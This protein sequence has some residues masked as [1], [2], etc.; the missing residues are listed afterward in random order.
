MRAIVY[1]S[2][3]EPEVLELADVPRPEP[4]PHEVLVR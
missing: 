3:G 4:Q 2:F 1:R